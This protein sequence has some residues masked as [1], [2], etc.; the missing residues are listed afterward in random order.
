MEQLLIT[1][2]NEGLDANTIYSIIKAIINEGHH[3]SGTNKYES[4]MKH[5]DKDISPK[6]KKVESFDNKEIPMHRE[7]DWGE[8]S[9]KPSFYGNVIMQKL[10][11]VDPETLKKFRENGIIKAMQDESIKLPLFRKR[12]GT[13]PQDVNIFC[14]SIEGTFDRALCILD[15]FFNEGEDSNNVINFERE[16]IAK[17]VNEIMNNPNI[18]IKQTNN[19]ESVIGDP[20]AVKELI[21]LKKR[22]KELNESFISERTYKEVENRAK[23]MLNAAKERLHVNNEIKPLSQQQVTHGRNA[24][25]ILNR[26][27]KGD[28]S[29]EEIENAMKEVTHQG[30]RANKNLKAYKDKIAKQEEDR[31]N[32]ELF[33][34]ITYGIGSTSKF[35]KTAKEYFNNLIDSKEYKEADEVTRKNLVK[36]LKDKIHKEYNDKTQSN[37]EQGYKKAAQSNQKKKTYEDQINLENKI[38]NTVL[39]NAASQA[40]KT[41][42]SVFTEFGMKNPL[43]FKQDK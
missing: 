23:E 32:R 29:Q 15:S 19:G 9:L 24:Q 39:A 33:G 16:Q 7:L 10:K 43:K 36:D 6:D 14:S 25:R 18:N 4:K 26:V 13:A 40:D 34:D 5:A 1:M 42:K 3:N 30:A 17:R 22:L 41:G 31:K 27:L 37:R 38:K 35:I 8:P 2:L 12:T 11:E 21:E 20:K 28:A